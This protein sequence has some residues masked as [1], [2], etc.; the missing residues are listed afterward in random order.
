MNNQ[1]VPHIPKITTAQMN[2]EDRLKIE[3]YDVKILQM[4]ENP[5]RSLVEVAVGLMGNDNNRKNVA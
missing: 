3:K 4:M 2:E 1:N 5:M